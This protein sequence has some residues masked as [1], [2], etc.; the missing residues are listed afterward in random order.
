[1]AAGRVE[2]QV[3]FLI[4]GNTDFDP[5]EVDRQRQLLTVLENVDGNFR[6]DL[7]TEVLNRQ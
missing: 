3:E 1:M 5:V 2:C 7:I 6:R 4:N